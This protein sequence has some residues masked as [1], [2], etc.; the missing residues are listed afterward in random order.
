MVQ[1]EVSNS[2]ELKSSDTSTA[3]RLST[4]GVVKVS[5]ADCDTLPDSSVAVICQ[6]YSVSGCRPRRSTVWSSFSKGLDTVP[7]SSALVSPYATSPVV[8]SS[9]DHENTTASLVGVA[10]APLITGGVVSGCRFPS[11]GSIGAA[12][13]KK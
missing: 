7:S 10:V 5:T 9:V 13:S 4:G 2:A 12:V 1:S 8:G 3:G 11:S 6:K